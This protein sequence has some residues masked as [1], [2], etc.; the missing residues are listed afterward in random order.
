MLFVY[1]LIGG[2]SGLPMQFS[3]RLGGFFLI[4]YIPEEIS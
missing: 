1:R 3:D 2:S 4:W